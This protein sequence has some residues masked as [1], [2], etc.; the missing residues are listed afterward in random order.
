MSQALNQE[1]LPSMSQNFIATRL[2]AEAEFKN[3]T[4]EVELVE[5][6]GPPDIHP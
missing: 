1:N 5:E 3:W 2:K 6:Q 4:S